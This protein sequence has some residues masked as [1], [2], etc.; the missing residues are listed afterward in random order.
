MSLLI[1]TSNKVCLFHSENQALLFFNYITPGTL[2]RFTMEKEIDRK[3]ISGSY[4]EVAH[5][6]TPASASVSLSQ[7]EDAPLTADMGWALKGPRS[8]FISLTKCTNF[9][10]KP[11]FKKRTLGI[12]QRLRM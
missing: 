11:S 6:P 5:P 4:M 7:S 10:V 9:C 3:T 8:L 2:T 12:K 1:K